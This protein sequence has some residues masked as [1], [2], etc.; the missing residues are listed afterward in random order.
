MRGWSFGP[1]IWSSEKIWARD[2][3]VSCHQGMSTSH[4]NGRD[5]TGRAGELRE[6]PGTVIL[7]V[8]RRRNQQRTE[9]RQL[10]I[11][12]QLSSRTEIQVNAI[13]ENSGNG[14][15]LHNK[16][17]CDNT[18]ELERLQESGKI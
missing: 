3:E 8:Q 5:C 18:V 1:W 11:K 6:L 16:F 12:L 14:L 17:L 7:S 4:G 10:I 13:T 2:Y 9:N 15:D